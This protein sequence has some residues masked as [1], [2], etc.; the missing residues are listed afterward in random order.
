MP[1]IFDRGGPRSGLHH[2]AT[3][4]LA[5]Y[6]GNLRYT[7][8][9][10]GEIYDAAVASHDDEWLLI[11]TADHSFRG[12]PM[13]KGIEEDVKRDK[14]RHVPLIMIQPR[15]PRH[16]VINTP[17]RLTSLREIIARWIDTGKLPAELTVDAVPPNAH[18]KG[19]LP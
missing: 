2:G 11:L 13:W 8:Q 4:E 6:Q 1:F 5:R 16:A 14:M 18:A 9:L 3:L 17:F 19:D 12:D 10:V 7:D 15:H